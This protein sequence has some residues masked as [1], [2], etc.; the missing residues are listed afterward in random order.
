[1]PGGRLVAA[2][3]PP[4]LEKLQAGVFQLRVVPLAI[5]ARCVRAQ[6]VS[7]RAADLDAC[8]RL[9]PQLLQRLFVTAE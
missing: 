6:E 1:V 4:V 7:K 9:T 8:C 3:A 5:L 2:S